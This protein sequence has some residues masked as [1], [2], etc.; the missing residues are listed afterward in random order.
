MQGCWNI[1]WKKWSV[2]AVP[3][4]INSPLLG[5]HLRLIIL[6]K[7]PFTSDNLSNILDQNV[8]H[9]NGKLGST[10]LNLHPRWA[11]IQARKWSSCLCRTPDYW[12]DT[13]QYTPAKIHCDQC[14]SSDEFSS[15]S[16]RCLVVRN[17]KS[18]RGI[19]LICI[20]RYGCWKFTSTKLLSTSVPSLNHHLKKKSILGDIAP[21]IS[22]L[23]CIS[24]GLKL[25]S[26]SQIPTSLK[27]GL[28][29]LQAP[30]WN[31]ANQLAVTKLIARITVGS[32][33]RHLAD[34]ET[35]WTEVT[36]I[37]PCQRFHG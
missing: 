4:G 19:K 8:I 22:F 17:L 30:S 31:L 26:V 15:C 23:L 11:R 5:S 16:L 7:T 18:W 28:L 14:K 33:T 2:K 10:D 3:A 24:A 32:V 27:K 37:L 20:G 21:Q 12:R 25:S 9:V 29:F 6:V 1:K 36:L 13:E 35:Y 34:S